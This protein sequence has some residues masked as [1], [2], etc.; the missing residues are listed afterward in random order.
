[1]SEFRN[2]NADKD[3][4]LLLGGIC[5]GGEDQGKLEV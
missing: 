1:M 5:F 4:N 2:M 3:L